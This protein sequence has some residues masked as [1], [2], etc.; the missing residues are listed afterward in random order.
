MVLGRKSLHPEDFVQRK[1]IG[2]YLILVTKS[3][4]LGI[5]TSR[6][7]LLS[8]KWRRRSGDG[9]QPGLIGVFPGAAGQPGRACVETEDEGSTRPASYG[10]GFLK[11]E[12]GCN[13]SGEHRDG[14]R[15]TV[16]KLKATGTNIGTR[17]RDRYSDARISGCAMTF[18][19]K[20]SG[21]MVVQRSLLSVEP[22]LLI[23]S[24]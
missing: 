17:S 7:E 1:R 16:L 5:Y 11:A 18:P 6:R 4:T 22:S 19:A 14:S 23:S 15:G 12:T 9:M 13:R 8:Q 10:Q 21:P 24:A 20:N 2:I 3:T